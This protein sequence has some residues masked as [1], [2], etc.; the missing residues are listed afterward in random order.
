[1][2]TPND[3]AVEEDDVGALIYREIQLRAEEGGGSSRSCQEKESIICFEPSSNFNSEEIACY[4]P[5]KRESSS[6]KDQPRKKVTKKKYRDGCT[7]DGRTN[8]AKRGG[9]FRR[10]GAKVK[11]KLCS[12]EGCTNNA[13]RG[14]V[15]IRHGAKLKRCSSEG[16]T[17]KVQK[18][19]MCKRH[20]ACR[21]T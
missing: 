20:G 16:S 21:N 12:S 17:K 1:M 4:Q 13:Q 15:C 19:G 9:V 6:E 7:A 10:H 2:V 5:G 8:D 3:S 18:G 11:R 14:G